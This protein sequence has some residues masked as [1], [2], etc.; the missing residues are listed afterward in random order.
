MRLQLK[1]DFLCLCGAAEKCVGAMC[2]SD[3]CKSLDPRQTAC[4]NDKLG[5]N[6]M[7]EQEKGSRAQG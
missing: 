3:G 7:D 1:Q 5:A 2:L 6:V 4:T